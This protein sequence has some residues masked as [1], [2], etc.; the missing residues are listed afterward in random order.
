MKE[1]IFSKIQHPRQANL[2][3]N[4]G[5]GSPQSEHD[6]NERFDEVENYL[7]ATRCSEEPLLCPRSII[8]VAD[9]IGVGLRSVPGCVARMIHLLCGYIIQSSV[10]S[11]S[12]RDLRFLILELQALHGRSVYTPSLTYDESGKNARSFLDG[13]AKCDHCNV[14]TALILCFACVD[15]FCLTCFDGIHSKGNRARHPSFRIHLCSVCNVSV[16]RLGAGENGAKLCE[17]CFSSYQLS[18]NIINPEDDIRSNR[19][20]LPD[21]VPVIPKDER[22]PHEEWIPFYDK[23]GHPYFFNFKTMESYRGGFTDSRVYTVDP[24]VPHEGSDVMT[25]MAKYKTPP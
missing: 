2:E 13:Y 18:P 12:V 7:H 21:M 9:I 19:I 6:I 23:F 10:G 17:D 4:L 11:I 25:R 20:A 24:P 16:A 8:E 1:R 14:S 15:H 22:R 3:Y 5:E